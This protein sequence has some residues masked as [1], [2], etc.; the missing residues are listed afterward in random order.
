MEAIA[1]TQ[2]WLPRKRS[3]IRAHNAR[4]I[5]HREDDDYCGHYMIVVAV[6]NDMCMNDSSYP[7][8]RRHVT[9]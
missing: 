7:L 5:Y 8:A 9:K 2:H 3:K 4:N 6:V 1:G